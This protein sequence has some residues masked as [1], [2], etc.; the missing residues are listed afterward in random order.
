MQKSLR[1][2]G[3]TL[4]VSLLMVMLV[5]AMTMVL[6]A[7]VTVSARRSSADQQT[8]LQARYAAESGVSR[9]QSQLDLMS[10]LLQVSALDTTV[11][12]SS[13]EADM[14]AMCALPSL[15]VFSG[16]ADLCSFTPTQGL[17]RVATGIN[18]R[19][20]LLVRAMGEAAFG[21]EG[22]PEATATIR[23][24]YWSNLFSGQ[25]GTLYTG[26]QDATYTAKFGMQPLRVERT[27]ENT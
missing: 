13:V 18:G 5:L 21:T 23:S 10:R 2:Q 9:V 22:I 1:T 26:G 19:T 14:A 27:L 3:A 16:K 24:Q 8:I 25:Q 15:P 7:Q 11:L 4:L 17:G 6:T 20:Q 12:N